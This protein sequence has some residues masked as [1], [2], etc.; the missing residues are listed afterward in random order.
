MRERPAVTWRDWS[1]RS[2]RSTP[3]S[4]EHPW[5]SLSTNV[6]SHGRL[7][8]SRSVAG[9]TGVTWSLG[10]V[11]YSGKRVKHCGVQKQRGAREVFLSAREYPGVQQV[12]QS[13]MERHEAVPWST[14]EYADRRG[15]AWNAEEYAEA[16]G[17]VEFRGVRGVPRSAAERRG[18]PRSASERVD[19]ADRRGV[20]RSAAECRGVRGVPRSAAECR[21]VRGVPR[22]AAECRGVRGVPRSGAECRGVRKVLWIPCVLGFPGH[23]VCLPQKLTTPFRGVEF[24]R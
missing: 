8:K 12:P 24:L 5:S 16:S 9:R 15:A 4:V 14:V 23:A 10:S 11:G 19:Y 2:V 7:V 6:D 3:D 22:S 21:G 1:P 18:A 20:P 17:V 13:D